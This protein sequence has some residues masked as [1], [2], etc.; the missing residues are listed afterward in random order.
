MTIMENRPRIVV[1]SRSFSRHPVLRAEL[2]TR[3]PDVTFNDLGRSLAGAELV[4][5]LADHDRA[6]V[7][8]EKIDAELL[9]AA[10]QIRVISKF[11][12]GLDNVDLAA[13]A[14][15]G[16][17]V[18]WTGGVNRRSVAELVI[19]LMVATLRGVVTSHMEVLRGTWRQ[20][21]GRLLS[22]RTVGLLGFGHVGQEVAQLLRP[23]A[24]RI[25]ANDI[26]DLSV[27][28]AE[29]GV[30]CVDLDTLLHQSEVLSLHV[31]L[32][33]RTRNLIDS[34]KLAQM[35]S[36][37]VLINTARGSLVDETALFA[38]LSGGHLAAAAF[39]VFADE[40]PKNSPLL[41]LPNFIA[42]SHIGGSAEEAVLAMGRAAIDGL[43]TAV[44]A[45]L[46]VPSWAGVE[47]P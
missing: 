16:V 21:P 18:G 14:A 5:F 12:V 24:C 4:D 6:I 25:L 13:A 32:T 20:F 19:A 10:P 29:H 31:P 44:D 2:S 1:L 23:F 47:K 34:T 22:G 43:D 26:R 3:Y 40:P 38:A 17:R 37:A 36:G 42:T 46:H 41:S 28:A 8:L 7:A 30:T 39:D 11:G 45:L 35:R 27:P 33:P 15:R 9:D